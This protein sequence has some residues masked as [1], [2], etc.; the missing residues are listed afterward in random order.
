MK[1]LARRLSAFLATLVTC[2]TL[3]EG[4]AF[5]QDAGPDARSQAA[6]DSNALPPFDTLHRP[7][8]RRDFD[9]V[10]RQSRV[11]RNALIG[12]G[13]V[14]AV[15]VAMV[16]V[17]A[18]RC[19]PSLGSEATDC[20]AVRSVLLPVGAT[21]S[22]MSGAGMLAAS[23]ML[24]LRNKHRRNI[25]REIRRRYSERRLHFHADSGGLAF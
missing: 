4:A 3:L 18:P 2:V 21:I 10:G 16:G 7:Y 12:T 5:A 17:S 1:E 24:A 9:E 14:F 6:P 11:L 25:E 20:D 23:I 8:D 15:G 19:K 22:L 13:A